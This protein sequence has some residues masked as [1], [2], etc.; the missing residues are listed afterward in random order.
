MTTAVIIVA[1][2]RGRRLGGDLPKQ[3]LP[4]GDATPIRLTVER[5]LQLEAVQ[6]ITPVIHPDDAAL[7]G[8][9][10][11]TLADPRLRAPV[12]GG[13]TRAGSV[14]NGL[15]SLADAAPGTV[16]IHDG[17]RPFVSRRVIQSVIDALASAD[18][19][20]AGLPVVDALWQTQ[21]GA[22]TQPIP[23]DGLWRAQTPQGFRF[24]PILAAHRAHDGSGADDVA[25]AREAGLHVSF[26]LGSEQ[27]Y[28]IT[29]QPDLDRAQLDVTR[30]TFDG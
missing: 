15:E 8:S 2:G 1:A 10:M 13:E 28:K 25:V 17:A 23:R 7:Y 16:L 24:A 6:S 3:Y 12:H 22:A 18:G 21:D 30:F 14:L 19:A 20:C 11:A 26:T 9:A 4:L 27:N 5:F 29:T